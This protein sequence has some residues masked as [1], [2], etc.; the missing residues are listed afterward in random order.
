[1]GEVLSR[2][3]AGAPRFSALVVAFT[4]LAA[5]ARAAD[6]LLY[7]PLAPGLA[8]DE[9]R[10]LQPGAHLQQY[11]EARRGA[12]GLVVVL[13]DGSKVERPAEAVVIFLS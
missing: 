5:P 6:L 11:A 7:L 13:P 12:K 8:W 10:R 2:K 4:A 3:C 9:T 1:M